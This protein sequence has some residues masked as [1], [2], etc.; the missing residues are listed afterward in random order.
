MSWGN[1]A[2]Y[3]NIKYPTA[4]KT[5]TTQNNSDGWFMAITPDLVTGVWTGADDRSVRFSTTDKGQGANMALP[6]YG[7]YMNKVY[8]DTTVQISKGDFE[9]PEGDLGVEIN[10]RGKSAH[11]TNGFPETPSWE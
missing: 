1:R 9:R 4:A 7:Y 2:K 11:E 10:C 3:G 8:A 5:G 6:I